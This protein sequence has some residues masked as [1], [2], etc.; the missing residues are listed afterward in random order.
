MVDGSPADE[1]AAAADWLQEAEGDAP[2][3]ELSSFGE[4]AEA[5][6]VADACD[7]LPEAMTHPDFVL[8]NVV[9][10]PEPSMVLVDWAAAGRGPRLW[11]LAFLLWAEGSKD[12]RRAE[13]AMA[14]YSRRVQLEPEELERLET[15]ITARPLVLDIWRLHHRGLS[16]ASAVQNA[17]HNRELAQ[18]I[19]TRVSSAIA[20]WSS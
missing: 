3:R 18:A 20:R 13:L 2:A 4:L 10:T 8:A 16:L 17:R 7:G 11:S 6:A 12:L 5:L 1:L 9:A 15:A 14:G 19:A